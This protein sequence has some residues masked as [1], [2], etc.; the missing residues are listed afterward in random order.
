MSQLPGN[1]FLL[2]L[3]F[4]DCDVECHCI[5]KWSTST[6]RALTIRW[7]F[8]ITSSFA[9]LFCFI[10]YSKA[11]QLASRLSFLSFTS[12][13]SFVKSSSIRSLSCSCVLNSVTRDVIEDK[14]SWKLQHPFTLLKQF[15]IRKQIFSLG[16]LHICAYITEFGYNLQDKST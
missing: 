10:W 16:F 7:S 5:T 13:T 9:M 4:L 15:N 12:F 3:L 14:T 2:E 6:S 8:E 1:Y 11:R